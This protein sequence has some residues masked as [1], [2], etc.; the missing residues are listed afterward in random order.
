MVLNQ[1]EE[2]QAPQQAL[3]TSSTGLTDVSSSSE[4]SVGPQPENHHRQQSHADRPNS[5]AR[6]AALQEQWWQ[7]TIV[8]R[9]L[10][11]VQANLAE[12]ERNSVFLQQHEPQ[13]ATVA[14]F[15]RS[16]I[17]TGPL[18]GK[19]G[20]SLVYEITGF[21]LDPAVSKRCTAEQQRLREEYCDQ[22]P[23]TFCIKH[24]NGSHLLAKS[25]KE[26]QCALSDLAT[27][28][29]YMSRLDHPNILSIRG[30]PLGGLSALANG[31]HDSYF[32]ITDRLGETLEQ[33]IQTNNKK[34]ASSKNNL[35]NE[36]QLLEKL[37]YALQLADALQYLHEHRIIFRD[38]KPQNIGFSL[39]DH[40]RIQLFDFG[41]CRELPHSDWHDE[42]FHMSGVGTRRYM[43]PELIIRDG[44]YNAKADV[45]SWALLFWEL[46]S[47]C[48]P[49][50]HYSAADHCAMVC[51]GGERPKLHPQCVPAP[52]RDILVHAWCDSVPD[53]W[54]TARVVAELTALTASKKVQHEEEPPTATT[55]RP[56]SRRLIK[57]VFDSPTGIIDYV[58]VDIVDSSPSCSERE[59]EILSLPVLPSKEPVGLRRSVSLEPRRSTISE[60]SG[61]SFRLDPDSV[62]GSSIDVPFL[63]HGDDGEDSTRNSVIDDDDEDDYYDEDVSSLHLNELDRELTICGQ[64]GIEVLCPVFLQRPS[65]LCK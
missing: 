16:E 54:S 64:H 23:G 63:F 47:G 41:L 19:G 40:H 12:M 53:R 24:L 9:S 61:L 45:Y 31:Q 25:P 14:V 7:R 5:F 50:A 30:L 1:I 35:A 52:L 17:R 42:V 44:R 57:P 43:A 26:F 59:D 36:A 4:T 34:K 29:A 62:L 60:E 3:K 48:K 2:L 51:Q 39:N 56:S 22:P 13:D 11:T 46:L 32:I 20:F 28:A 8:K 65:L 21:C 55:P 10:K 58:D 38:L 15:K 18:L 49:Y 27:E 6:R 37:E 33:W